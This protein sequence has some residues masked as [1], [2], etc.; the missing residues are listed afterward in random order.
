MVGIGGM[1]RLLSTDCYRYGTGLTVSRVQPG[2]PYY[3]YHPYS[4][5]GLATKKAPAKAPLDRLG[6]R[7]GRPAVWIIGR[8][9]LRFRGPALAMP[10]SAAGLSRA[11]QQAST[12]LIR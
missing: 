7:G 2:H 11:L 6:G 4:P 8:N 3:A 12:W 5:W 10:V 9:R 1:F